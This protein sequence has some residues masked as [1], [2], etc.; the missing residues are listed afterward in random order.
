MLL[1]LLYALHKAASMTP[2]APAQQT[3]HQP[4]QEQHLIL[5]FDINETILVGDE[6]GG[7]TRQDCFNKMLAKSAFVQMPPANAKYDYEST[8][9]VVPTHWVNG[10][11]LKDG[12][13]T[14]CS[15]VDVR[16]EEI[17]PLHTDWQWPEGCCPYYRTAYKKRAKTFVE[18]HGSIYRNVYNQLRIAFPGHVGDHIPHDD[19][20]HHPHD[21]IDDMFSHILPAFFHTLRNL[22]DDSQTT[23][24]LRTFGSDL[25]DIAAAVSAFAR[26]QHP[27]HSD[28]V[29]ESLV[30]SEDALVQG[31]WAKSI[32]STA[33]QIESNINGDNNTSKSCAAEEERDFF[34]Y[35]LWK[36]DQL[37]ASGDAEVL[38]FLHS[39]TI[40]GIQDHYEHWRDHKYEPWAGKPVWVPNDPNYHHVLLDDNM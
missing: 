29:S 21:A 6:A 11:P 18:H 9:S 25:P 7:D 22:P 28:Y 27:D 30:L 32:A 4:Q 8:S 15:N 37:V 2:D 5:H 19:N 31:R 26:G 23:I 39:H 3:Q 12:P 36:K 24:V 14:S 16:V 33:A 13:T 34:V 1:L 35:Q 10:L 40:C 17:P 20:N 38:Q